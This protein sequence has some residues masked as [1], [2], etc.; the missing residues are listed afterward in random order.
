MAENAAH[1]MTSRKQEEREKHRTVG[2]LLLLVPSEGPLLY[3]TAPPTFGA[4]LL[5]QFA[6]H[7]LI[8]L[9]TRSVLH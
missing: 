9:E 8:V 5:Y 4:G 6:A 2:L 3:G 7:T 1:L